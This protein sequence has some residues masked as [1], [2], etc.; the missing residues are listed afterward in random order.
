MTIQSMIDQ[1]RNS[2]IEKAQLV[3][4]NDRLLEENMQ[5][6]S[7]IDEMNKINARMHRE[8]VQRISARNAYIRITQAEIKDLKEQVEHANNMVLAWR[9]KGFSQ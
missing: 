3:E 9:E 8:E 2:L 4:Q 5:L 1:L 6:K 7:Q